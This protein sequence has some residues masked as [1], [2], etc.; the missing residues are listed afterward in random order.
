MIG[1]GR[2][3]DLWQLGA[4]R[5]L[6]G[7]SLEERQYKALFNGKRANAVFSDPPFNVRINGHVS[8]NGQV[9]HREFAMAS[10]EMTEAQFVAFLSTSLGLMAKYN[11]PGALHYV[12]MDF[13]HQFELLQAGKSV[14]DDLLNVCV[15]VK[16]KGGMG[17]FYRSQHEL[18]FVY[19]N[20]GQQA[21]Q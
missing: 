21:P 6:C 13:R 18:V 11:A 3:L 20:R 15:W 17:S 7:S 5:V 12:C 1:C 4:H 8:G 10:G 2:S 19:Q 9:R 16:N 14:Y